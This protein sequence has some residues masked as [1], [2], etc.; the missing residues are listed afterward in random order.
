MWHRVSPDLNLGSVAKQKRLASKS[1]R[2]IFKISVTRN[3]HENFYRPQRSWA[4]VIFSQACLSTGGGGVCLSACWDIA[5]RTRPPSPRP[6]HTTSRTTPPPDHTPPRADTPP[7]QT[8]PGADTPP[9]SPGSRLQH[10]VNERP[11]RI[12]LQCILVLLIIL[13]VADRTRCMPRS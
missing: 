6:D 3:I 11:L 13:L 5:P 7:E 8:P 10:T 2:A 1:M 9:P 12:L 4:K